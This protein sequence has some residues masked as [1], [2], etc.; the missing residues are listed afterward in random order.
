MTDKR[1]PKRTAFLTATCAAALFVGVAMADTI[2]VDQGGDITELCG[3]DPIR[4][5]LVDGWGGD[6]WRK[7]TFAELQDEPSKCPNVTAEDWVDAGGD[8]QAYAAAINGF[9]V[10]GYEVI[11]AFTD[12]GDAA[13]PT[14]R[15][16]NGNGTTMVPYFGVLSGNVGTDYAVNPYQDS[17]AI[18]KQ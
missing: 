7:I 15:E 5:A 2:R 10:Q 13:I 11:H 14:Y 18:G 4:V 6:T 12:F 1:I 3:T 9:A 8:Q 16:A 17:I